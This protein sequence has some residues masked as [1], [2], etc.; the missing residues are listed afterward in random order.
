MLGPPVLI[1]HIFT[2]LCIAGTVKGVKFV[3]VMTY[4]HLGV[5]LQG[6]W[7][8]LGFLDQDDSPNCA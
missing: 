7:G 8:S 4:S 1:T 2:E 5:V 6:I 3:L